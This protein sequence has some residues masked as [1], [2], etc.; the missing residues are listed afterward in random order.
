[1]DTNETS[2]KLQYLTSVFSQISLMSP[3]PENEYIEDIQFI[4]VFILQCSDLIKQSIYSDIC[5]IIEERSECKNEDGFINYPQLL[6]CT[7][8]S[9][10]TL[11]A[12][13]IVLVIWLVYMFLSLAFVVDNFFCPSLE[14]IAKTLRMNDNVAGV[15]LLA[16]GNGAPDVFCAIVA[17]KSNGTSG[18]RLAVGGLLGSGIF[19]TTV[20]VGSI[21]MVT[22]FRIKT[23]IAYL[24]D[25]I[26]YMGACFWM[27]YVVWDGGIS[28]QEAIGFICLYAVY[29]IIVVMTPRLMEWIERLRDSQQRGHIAKSIAGDLHRETTSQ[30]GLIKS[31]LLTI[32]PVDI[33]HWKQT[34]L[35]SKLCAIMKVPINFVVTLTTP[36]VDYSK[37]KHNWNRLLNSLHC[38]TGSLFFV[39]VVKVVL[40]SVSD[41]VLVWLITICVGTLLALI[42]FVTSTNHVPPCYQW[43][44]QGTGQ[45]VFAYIGFFVG[46]IWI[47]VIANELINILM[48]I[49][50]I[51]SLSDDVIGILLLTVGNSIADLFTNIANAKTGRPVMS[52]S[53]CVGGPLLNLMLGFG[54]SCTIGTLRKGDKLLLGSGPMQYLLFVTLGVSLAS[55]LLIMVLSRFRVTKWYGI[56]LWCIYLVFLVMALLIETDVI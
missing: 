40:S 25:I 50:I 51:F 26:V 35:L 19:I 18:I 5:H 41:N 34:S 48:T 13:L 11:Y 17:V 4:S 49:G 45:E 1:M 38:I 7:S 20:V 39:F 42:V 21:A 47:Y 15:T 23:E 31:F 55:S 9:Q 8:Q 32:C 12:G 2:T 24:R 22:N 3:Y 43:F 29:V 54:I 52:I 53:A 46:V 28:L 6:Y 36:V 30:T 27:Y 16:L 37:E 33:I 10:T 56:Y 44:F 14:V